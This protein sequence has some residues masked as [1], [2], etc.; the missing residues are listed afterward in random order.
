VPERRQQELPT[1]EAEAPQGTH[2][3]QQRGGG[4]F[5][6]RGQAGRQGGRQTLSSSDLVSQYGSI[7]RCVWWQRD[8]QTMRVV[9]LSVKQ[10]P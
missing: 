8:F 3:R 9:W 6:G 2:P 10:F 4:G 5:L 1:V 7:V